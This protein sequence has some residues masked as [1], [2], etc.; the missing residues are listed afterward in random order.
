MTF[1]GIG[2]MVVPWL[3]GAVAARSSI[4]AGMGMLIVLL[5]ALAVLAGV[6]RKTMNN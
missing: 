4:M 3:V 2:F 6:M 5:A 1:S